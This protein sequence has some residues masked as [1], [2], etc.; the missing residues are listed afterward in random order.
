MG[1]ILRIFILTFMQLLQRF[2][3]VGAGGF[4]PPTSSVS[5]KRSPPELRAFNITLTK[6]DNSRNDIENVK[7]NKN[8][9]QE[10]PFTF[11]NYNK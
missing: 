7:E 10:I 3:M 9:C 1:I 5:G 11:Y 6:S 4:E 8:L 2:F